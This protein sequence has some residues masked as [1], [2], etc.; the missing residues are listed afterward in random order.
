MTWTVLLRHIF[1]IGIPPR[2]GIDIG[3]GVNRDGT[4]S[5]LMATTLVAVKIEVKYFT[6]DQASFLDGNTV[7]KF[8]SQAAI[9]R[10]SSPTEE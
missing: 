6:F 1:A 10:F 4:R 9:I 7:H 8:S 5:L 3:I 2:H